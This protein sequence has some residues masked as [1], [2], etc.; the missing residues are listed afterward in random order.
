MHAISPRQR[1]AFL[2]VAAV[3][4]VAAVVGLGATGGDDRPAERAASGRV[5]TLTPGRTRELTYAQGDRVTFRVRTEEAEEV[6]VHGYDVERETQPGR[7]VT[8]SFTA[9]IAGVFEVEL[10][11]E[12]AVLARLRVEPR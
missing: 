2:A 1:L 12:E 10:H 5:P 7:P 9:T 6:H 4:A 11:H 3:I 8:I